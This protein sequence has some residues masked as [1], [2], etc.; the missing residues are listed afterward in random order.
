MP[1][2]RKSPQSSVKP[3]DYEQGCWA[4]YNAKDVFLMGK[5]SY[6]LKCISDDFN[7]TFGVRPFLIIQREWTDRDFSLVNC[8]Y[9][10][11]IHNWFAVPTMDM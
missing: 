5:L 11:G 6:I 2:G 3:L 4:D 9:L 10:D 1:A 7:S 8:P